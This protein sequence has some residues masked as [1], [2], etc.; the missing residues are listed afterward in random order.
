M[1]LHLGQSVVVDDRYILGMYDL[2]ITSQSHIT[3]DFLARAEKNGQ[4]INVS[5]EIPRSFVVYDDGDKVRVYISQLST[6]TLLR[7]AEHPKF[8]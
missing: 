6:S 1:Y 3:R 4:V 7:R 2:D 5:E 8:D